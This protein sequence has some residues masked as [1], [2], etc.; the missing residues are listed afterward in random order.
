MSTSAAGA[1][2]SSLLLYIACRCADA[3]GA[4]SAA[5]ATQTSAATTDV[6]STPASAADRGA[7]VPS[8]N[9]G[10]S[11][12]H[13]SKIKR[14]RGPTQ[15][16]ERTPAEQCEQLL[17][18]IRS[19]RQ[20]LADSPFF[21]RLMAILS[22]TATSHLHHM[23]YS[24]YMPDEPG[25]PG[26]AAAVR[27]ADVE[28]R[29]GTVTVGDGG[30]HT[31]AAVEESAKDGS[32]METSS[33]E[34]AGGGVGGSGVAT[35]L[36]RWHCMRSLVVYGLGSPHLSRVSRYQLALVLLLRDQILSGLTSP[37]HL[38]D[39][40]FDD[41]DRLAL[42]QLG[43]QVV[44][45]DEGAARRVVEP[46]FF[47]MPHCEAELYDAL[48]RANWGGG[49]GCFSDP[50]AAATGSSSC[51]H[52]RSSGGLPLLVVLGNSFRQYLERWRMRRAGS[53]GAGGGSHKAH[54]AHR[55]HPQGGGAPGPVVRSCLAGAVAEF[56]TPDLR[57]P[58]PS[59]FNC[60]SLHLFPPSERLERL[61][62]VGPDAVVVDATGLVESAGGKAEEVGGSTAMETV[63]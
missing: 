47:Y 48:L 14:Q 24:S 54:N 53:G 6:T 31:R 18:S 34:G 16:R 46:T 13:A 41:V 29:T 37:V 50:A 33:A 15:I 38:Y 10:S 55:A 35:P 58:V 25:A 44:D 57:F 2:F 20:E 3:R 62:A 17:S 5:C 59:A 11:A 51:S 30:C 7:V 1:V 40:A 61:V 21:A 19:C 12:F 4:G 36:T 60:M 56:V 45:V 8:S 22:E 32:D 42:E 28:G 9:A 26:M 23:P 43:L 52:S 27:L 49:V 63:S 39:P